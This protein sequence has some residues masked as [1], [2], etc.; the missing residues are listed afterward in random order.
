AEGKA[1]GGY[2]CRL[3]SPIE[4]LLYPFLGQLLGWLPP[5]QEA[6]KLLKGA[7]VILLGVLTYR[8]QGAPAI[9]MVKEV[10]NFEGHG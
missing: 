10:I 6:L 4:E 1:V 7:T 5:I 9:K 8:A 2:G 3:S